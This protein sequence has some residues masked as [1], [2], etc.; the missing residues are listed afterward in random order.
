VLE[1]HR[2]TKTALLDTH[3][4][5]KAVSLPWGAGVDSIAID[6]MGRFIMYD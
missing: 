3:V 2:T 5:G 6:P 4:N 1:S